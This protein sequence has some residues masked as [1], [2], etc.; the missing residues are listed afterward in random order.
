MPRKRVGADNDQAYAIL[1]AVFRMHWSA[2][3]AQGIAWRH[4][5]YAQ[6]KQAEDQQMVNFRAKIFLEAPDAHVLRT[7]HFCY[8]VFAFNRG[9]A[10]L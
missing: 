10:R 3:R 2:W 4:P 5:A 1:T 9:R 7:G 6:S 8:G